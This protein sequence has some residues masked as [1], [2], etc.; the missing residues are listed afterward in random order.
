M[1]IITLNQGKDPPFSLIGKTNLIIIIFFADALYLFHYITVDS[2]G[3]WKRN[4]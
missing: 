1:I 2:Q 3:L 4:S